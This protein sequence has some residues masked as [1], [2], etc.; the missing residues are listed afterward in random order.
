MDLMTTQLGCELNGGRGFRSASSQRQAVIKLAKHVH[1]LRGQG[2][3][4]EALEAEHDG[5]RLLL[6]GL[7]EAIVGGAR[8]AE[9]VEL[10]NISIDFCAIHVAN[11]KG[12]MQN[13][14][15]AGWDAH[16]AAHKQLLA[17]FVGARRRASGGG[18]SFA[19]LDAIDSLHAFH[20]HVTIWDLSAT[21]PGRATA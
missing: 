14:D 11:E 5:I 7:K 19:M 4:S 13:R 3:A 15:Y 9:I 16:V 1:T 17:K 10:L 2:C 8:S 21:V 18:L 20:E 6:Q 12:F